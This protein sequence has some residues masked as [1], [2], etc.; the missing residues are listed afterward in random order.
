MK[1][2]ARIFR[3]STDW[4]KRLKKELNPEQYFFVT[5]N[6]PAILGIAG[7][8][9]GK[10]RALTYRVAH[11]LYENVP[12]GRILLVTF[13][14]KAAQEMKKRVKE[15]LGYLPEGLWAGTFHSIGARV[16]RRHARLTGREANFSILDEDDRE[17]MLKSILAS[18]IP[19]PAAKEKNF[20]KKGAAGKILSLSRNSNSPLDFFI[21][22]N[23]PEMIDYIPLF[24]QLEVLYEEKKTPCQCL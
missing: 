13:T 11:L 22:E 19:K 12:P 14:N 18:L 21:K 4:Y 24:Q 16:L 5:H 1:E 15:I 17:R 8:G 10:T 6:S 20:F 23:N 3:N 9:S 2:L 7:P